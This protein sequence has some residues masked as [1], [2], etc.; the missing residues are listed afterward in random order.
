MSFLASIL[1]GTALTIDSN[2]ASLRPAEDVSHLA[3]EENTVEPLLRAGHLPARA[4]AEDSGVV[5]ID[6]FPFG[7]PGA[8]ITGPHDGATKNG[9]RPVGV[10]PR[11][12]SIWAPFRSECDWEFARWAK[13]SGLSSSAITDLLA[14]P[15]VCIAL[16]LLH[17]VPSE[18]MRCKRLS[19]SSGCRI[20]TRENLTISLTM[21]WLAHPRFNVGNSTSDTSTCGFFVA[22]PCN[23]SDRCMVTLN[24][25]NTWSFHQSGITPTSG[26]HAVL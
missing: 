15:E 10:G 16:H 8:P 17:H 23:V 25:R 13:L 9:S 2:I 14:I 6:R 20:K 4:E 1:L 18:L 19:T 21:T 22:M 26:E 24:S 5:I 3:G 7:S 11:G 12:D